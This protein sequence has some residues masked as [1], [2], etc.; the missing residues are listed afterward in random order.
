MATGTRPAGWSRSQTN[1]A[2][3]HAALAFVQNWKFKPALKAGVAVR[4]VMR[5][6]IH[7][8]HEPGQPK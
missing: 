3:G 1:E 2:F 4:T 6:P 8:E 7:F 5:V